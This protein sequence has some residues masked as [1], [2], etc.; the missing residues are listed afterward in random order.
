MRHIITWGVGEMEEGRKDFPSFVAAREYVKE[1]GEP[2][3]EEIAT[4]F[5]EGQIVYPT[6]F[7]EGDWI[8]YE[9]RA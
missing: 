4:L 6:T 2:T 9:L 3:P 5:S 7:G 1:I 8:R